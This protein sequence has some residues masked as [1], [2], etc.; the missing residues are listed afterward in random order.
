MTPDLDPQE[1]QRAAGVFDKLRDAPPGERD[2]LLDAACAGDA[3]LRARVRR[4]LEADRTAGSFLEMRAIDDL[5]V[6]VSVEAPK[7]PAPGTVFGNYRL[8]ARIGA[9]GMGV[10]Y[11][12]QDLR[13]RRRVAIKILQ[14]HFGADSA[15]RIRRFQQEARATTILN[16]PNIVSI[17]DADFDQGFYYIAMEFVEGRTLR[18][19][20]SSQSGKLET[21]AVLDLISQTASALNAAHEAGIV[22]RDI[23]PENILVR[24]DGIVKVLDFG[25]AKLLPEPAD[26]GHPVSELRT[27]A[28]MLAG[29]IQYLSPE[30]V[31]GKPVD[32]RSDLFSLGV[33][34]YELVTGSRPFDGPTDG[35]VYDAILHRTP[36]PPSTTL[37]E[38]DAPVD[39]L[40]LRS[41]EKDPE[42]RFQTASDLRSACRR[43]IRDLSNGTALTAPP[44]RITKR[45]S[46]RFWIFAT[47]ALA[48]ALTVA[49]WA[50]WRSST[51]E[52]NRPLLQL[53]LEVGE[54][55]SQFALS[56][57]GIEL[58]MVTEKGLAIRRL[59][60]GRSTPLA[61]TEGASYPFFSPDGQWVAFFAGRKL[62]K[63][64]VAGGAPVILCDAASGRGGSWGVDG[65]IVLAPNSLGGLYRVPS[66]GGPAELV[67]A[68]QDSGHGVSGYRWPQVLP[69]GKGILF[70]TNNAGGTIGSLMVLAPDRTVRTLVDHSSYGQSMG[71]YLV[72]SQRGRLFTVPFDRDQ[73]KITGPA[74]PLVDGVASDTSRGAI[75]ESAPSGTLV[76]RGATPGVT[77][78][79]MWFD[80]A[81]N[82]EPI[83][84]PPAAYVSPAV[85]P[86]GRRLALAVADEAIH[87]LWIYDLK[88]SIMSRLTFDAEPQFLPVWTRD[89]EF[90]VFRSG[91]DIAWIRSDG[92]GKVE[93]LAAPVSDP[94]PTS[95]S[96]DGKWL[97]FAAESPSTGW[98][99]WVAR[100]RESAGALTFETPRPLLQQTGGQYAPVVSPDGRWL[101]YASDESG[102]GEV[103]VTP[104]SPDGPPRNG[105]WQVSKDGGIY[106]RWSREGRFIVFRSPDRHVMAADYAAAGESFASGPPRRWTP[107]RL[108]AAAGFPSFDLGPDSRLAGVFEVGSETPMTHL[109]VLL[110]VNDELHRREKQPG[111]LP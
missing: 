85:S 30:Q 66:S 34:W 35:A 61:G 62:Q 94:L 95:F 98:D 87:N 10:V 43:L 99:I 75:F 90:L 77:S 59:D 81:G 7:S 51:R 101:A 9:G 78:S 17:F 82:N 74:S 93:R 111:G 106:P 32:P 31:A 67:T 53:D 89:G 21:P 38:P 24:P 83:P 107:R 47:T 39:A 42:L 33:V 49:L 23:K 11:E 27:R 18:R 5:A 50:P 44:A 92:S 72:Y 100:A 97:V 26:S 65:Y 12:G 110:N 25:L 86:D 109:R 2:S 63:I 103:Y 6:L 19:I 91:S 52:A 71:N 80:T 45:R 36:T 48:F 22:H 76:Y 16:H 14:L 64:A 1:Y 58:A 57:D 68:V 73:L 79:L 88:R 56:P 28:G 40:I 3:P 37:A 102:R 8:G 70:T 41:I 15:E 55:L 105:K 69:Q 20:I 96:P 60:E 46:G 13:L 4:L 108:D 54:E 84:A 104:F 29:T